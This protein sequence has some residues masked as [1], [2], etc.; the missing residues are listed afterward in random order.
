MKMHNLIGQSLKIKSCKDSSMWYNG[1]IGRTFI[2]KDC[3]EE[4][5]YKVHQPEGYINFVKF[6]D[7]DL[8]INDENT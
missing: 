7:A 6:E 4:L 5:G 3:W 2:I 8:V 1:Y